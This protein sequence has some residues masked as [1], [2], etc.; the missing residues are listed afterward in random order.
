[1]LS[2]DIFFFCAGYF[3]E[4]SSNFSLNCGKDNKGNETQIR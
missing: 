2:Q 3:C 1:M 4:N